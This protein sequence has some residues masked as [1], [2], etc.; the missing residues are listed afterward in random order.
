MARFSG[1][2]IRNIAI[3]GNFGE[4]KTTLAEAMLFNGKAIERQGTVANGNTVM[5]YDGEEIA[6]KMSISLSIASVV[7]ENTKINIIDVPGFLDFSGEE[8]A[9]LTACAGAVLVMDANGQITVGAEKTIEYC[10]KRR[11]PMIIF[12]NG[13]DKDNADYTGTV[14]ALREKYG[15][16]LAPIQ[17][18]IME[19]GKMQG[20]VSLISGKAFEFID[21]GAKQIEIPSGMSGDVEV[22]RVEVMETAAEN[23][24]TLMEKYFMDGVL[25]GDDVIFGVKKGIIKGSCIPIVSGC[26]LYNRGVINLLNE[27]V[28]LMP[29]P[30]DR[31]DVVALDK[32]GNP[33]NVYC[34]EDAPFSGQVFKTIAD[35]FVG[36]LSIVRIYS[37]VMQSGMTVINGRTGDKE[38]IN[39][40]YILKGKK[41]E[42]VAELCAGDIGAVAKMASVKTGD[43]LYQEGNKVT[44]P[45]LQFE[46]PN[47]AMAIAAAKHDEEDK[48]FQGFYKLAEEDMSF[49][50]EKDPMTGETVVKGQGETQLKVLCKKLKAKFGV[51]AELKEPKIAYRETIKGTA[52]ARGRHKRQ[53]GGSGQFGDVEVRFEPGAADGEYEFVDAVVGGA[54]PRNFIPAVDKGLRE[55]MK[56]GVLA[57]FPVVNVK[58]TLYDGSSHPVDSNEISFVCAAKLS[59]DEAMPKAKPVIL[60]PVD[61]VKVTVPDAYTGD[62]IGDFNKRRG[63]IT[64]METVEGKQVLTAEVPKVEMAKYAIDLRGMTQG[65]GAYVE[66]FVRYEEVPFEKSEEIIKNAKK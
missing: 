64:G 47:L 34:D 51:D 23:D 39:Q 66:K 31:T 58:C 65:R 14:S 18:P 55:A 42:T 25:T 57:G 35:P 37:G 61:E 52:S 63:R 49:K 13:M 30:I 22:M 41:Q 6:R 60:E 62:V 11:K 21:N 36:K 24:D 8:T 26:A 16:K 17:A 44:Y 59:Y 28:D 43:T 3:V 50:I 5:D 9:A 27:I 19:N 40:L 33:I 54:V 38:R 46:E 45:Q 1:N 12:I 53:N 7:W 29:A 10:L 20:Y 48:V 15:K 32:D 4:G 2:N 56:S